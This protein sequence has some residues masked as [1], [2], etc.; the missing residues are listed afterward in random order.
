MGCSRSFDDEIHELDS[1]IKLDLNYSNGESVAGNE[2][3][4][5]GSVSSQYPVAKNEISLNS[6]AW[7]NL[8]GLS[9]WETQLTL[10]PGA[11]VIRLRISTTNGYE[12]EFEYTLYNLLEKIAPIPTPLGKASYNEALFNNGWFYVTGGKS[13]NFDALASFYRFNP[14]TRTIEALP[15]IPLPGFSHNLAFYNDSLYIVSGG[16]Y[17]RGFD[18]LSAMEWIFKYSGSWNSIPVTSSESYLDSSDGA[19]VTKPMGRGAAASARV[20]DKLYLFGGYDVLT[21][22]DDETRFT[23][24]G[25]VLEYDLSSGGST[26][27]FKKPGV[28]YLL[29]AKAV[30]HNNGIFIFGGFNVLTQ[31]YS[32]AVYYYVPSSNQLYVL[33]E[34]LIFSRMA[35]GASKIDSRVVLFGGYGKDNSNKTTYL[36]FVETFDLNTFKTRILKPLP[37]ALCFIGAETDG[38]DI[39]L[40]GG[41]GEGWKLT[42]IYKYHIKKDPDF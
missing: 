7:N 36:D 38:E 23:F 39:Y 30:S 8:N 12:Q 16:N 10:V 28:L 15:T 20:G 3:S 13:G 25:D 24:K 4:L 31:S 9:S 19:I 37:F 32:N 33:S 27:T 11:N 14:L 40:F 5:R 17:Y 18:Q 21:F 41:E 6:S 42:D 1:Q 2:I 35:M 26:F 34:K 22:Y 29:Y